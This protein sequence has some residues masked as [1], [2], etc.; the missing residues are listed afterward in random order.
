MGDFMREFLNKLEENGFWIDSNVY[1]LKELG[2]VILVAEDTNPNTPLHLICRGSEGVNI[3][4]LSS[5][6]GDVEGVQDIIIEYAGRIKVRDY[7]ETVISMEIEKYMD[8]DIVAICERFEQ[9]GCNLVFPGFDPKQNKVVLLV[10]ADENPNTCLSAISWP[11]NKKE[12]NWFISF[13]M[14][15]MRKKQ[16]P[17]SCIT[18]G[19]FSVS[20]ILNMDDKMLRRRLLGNVIALKDL[21][22]VRQ[23]LSE[24]KQAR[25][26]NP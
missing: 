10:A 12:K 7:T 1:T 19:F 21:E 22:L 25:I 3:Y 20:D 2:E 9:I 17:E 8:D 14:L 26:D 16:H 18:H 15:F 13:G 5:W 23:Y 4:D 24:R 6:S 11:K